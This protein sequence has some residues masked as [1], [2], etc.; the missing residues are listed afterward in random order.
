MAQLPCCS[1]VAREELKLQHADLHVPTLRT[2]PSILSPHTE[3]QH[4][5]PHAIQISG[6]GATLRVFQGL[7]MNN[8]PQAPQRNPPYTCCE[9]TPDQPQSA[10]MAASYH[11]GGTMIQPPHYQSFLGNDENVHSRMTTSWPRPYNHPDNWHTPG[12]PPPA[13]SQQRRGTH[14]QRGPAEEYANLPSS[15]DPYAANHSLGSESRRWTGVWRNESRSTAQ[16]SDAQSQTTVPHLQ[17]RTAYQHSNSNSEYPTHSNQS[18]HVLQAFRDLEIQNHSVSIV[19][20]MY[21]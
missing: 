12:A 17:P 10:M 8:H 14:F 20:P 13:L 3:S 2:Q 7:I 16:E 4:D 19:R 15:Q 18:E 9:V 1:P 5:T 21:L 6:P 11:V